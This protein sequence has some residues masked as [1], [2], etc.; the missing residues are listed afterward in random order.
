MFHGVWPQLL[1]SALWIASLPA[2]WT[3]LRRPSLRSLGF[4]SLLL[5]ASVLAHPFGMLTAVVSAVAWP[6][7]L[8]AT[9]T[10][11]KLPGG[12]IRWWLIIHAVA[13]LICAGWVVTFLASAGAMSRSPVPYEPLG[14]LATEL[15]AG[16]LFRDH[17]AWIGPLAI[18]GM[19]V[20]IRRGRAMAWLGVGLVC[21]LLILASQ[22]SITV[23]RLDLVLSAF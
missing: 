22:A 20:A 3:A 9:G 1:S 17:R 21:A 6:I 12:Q 16:E 8:W 7:V 14:T 13:A 2:T 4:A 11:R 15:L 5:G 23:V 10:M 18:V 19:I